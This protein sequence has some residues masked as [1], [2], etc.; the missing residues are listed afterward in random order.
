[1]AVARLLSLARGRTDGCAPLLVGRRHVLE[2]CR[3]GYAGRVEHP[4]PLTEV[5]R[6]LEALRHRLIAMSAEDLTQAETEEI[7]REVSAIRLQLKRLAFDQSR[8]AH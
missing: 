1:M 5:S 8:S 3:N 4:I 7:S 2:A 6:E